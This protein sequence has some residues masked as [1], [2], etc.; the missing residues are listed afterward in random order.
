MTFKPAGGLPGLTNIIVRVT[1]SAVAAISSNAMFAPYQL[2][3]H[4]A[5]VP[6]D[7]IPPTAS[8]T[9]LTNG[10]T[11]TGLFFI[12]GSASDNVGVQKVELRIDGGNWIAVNGTTGWNYNFNSPNFLNGLHVIDVRATDTSGN[13][14]GVTS[15]NVRLINEPGIY[16]LRLSAGNSSDVTDCNGNTWLKEKAYTIGDFGYSGGA[17]GF[18]ANTISG[19]CAQGQSLFQHEHFS[20]DSGGVLYEFDC[21]EGIYEITL[22]NSETFWNGP[23]QRQFNVTI[24]G[25][26]VLTNFDIYAAGGGMNLPIT[27]I[28]TTAV[29]NSQLKVLFLPV[30]DNTRISGLQ[31]R[32]IGDVYSDTDGIPDWWRLAYFNHPAGAAADKSRGIDDADGDGVSNLTEFLNGTDPS[33]SSSFPIVPAFDIN[34]IAMI[35]SNIQIYCPSV[36]NWSYQ[37]LG[38]DSLDTSSGWTNLGPALPGNGGELLFMDSIGPSGERFYRVQAR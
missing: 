10:A 26:Q 34:Q 21:P 29:S 15:A 19:I 35:D 30:V 16:F 27:N 23:G 36:T 37:L 2:Q 5:A 6:A 11:I 7:T 4:T 33:N 3:F 38:R 22:L 14:S 1:N 20:T 9:S 25:Q 32:R 13:I 12:S 17:T 28:F 8:F 24:Q 31:V 18:V